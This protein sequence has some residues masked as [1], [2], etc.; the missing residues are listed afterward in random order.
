MSRSEG[1]SEVQVSR[2]GQA[3]PFSSPATPPHPHISQW[4]RFT[5]PERLPLQPFR[6]DRLNRLPLPPSVAMATSKVA[7]LSGAGSFPS[8]QLEKQRGGGVDPLQKIQQ[9]EKSLVFVRENHAF[10]LKGLHDEV[11]ELKQKNRGWLGNIFYVK[12]CEMFSVLSCV[13]CS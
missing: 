5:V 12:F 7:T 3:F 10:M 6:Q 1:K 13:I 9:L 11:A 8:L 4:C 2:P